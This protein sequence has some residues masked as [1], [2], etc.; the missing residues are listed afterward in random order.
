[1]NRFV[2]S[3][4]ISL[5][6]AIMVYL[7]GVFLIQEYQLQLGTKKKF[8]EIALLVLLMLIILMGTAVSGKP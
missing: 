4:K 1:M 2:E 6:L 7:V 8:A 5:L 3:Q